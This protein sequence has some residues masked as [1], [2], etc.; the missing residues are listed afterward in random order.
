MENLELAIAEI[1]EKLPGL[2]LLENEPMAAHSSFRIGGP[3]RALAAPADVTGLSKVCDLLKQHHVA[4][5]I[6]GNGT[7][8]LFPDEGLNDLFLLSTEKLQNIFLLP[9]GAVYAE[10]GVSLARLS[11]FACE[12]GLAGLEF[13]SGIPGTL[14]GGCMMNAGAYGGELKDVI[15]SVVILYLPDQTLYELSAEQCAF[16]YRQSYFQKTPGCV[17]LSAVLRLPQ[18]D[19]DA[20]L[21][22]MQELGEKRRAKQPL[23]LPSAGSA[24]R[25]PE[26][27][28]AAALIDEAGLKGYTVGG[29]QVS[30]KHAGFV[31]NKGGATSHDVY[32][33][34]MYVRNTVYEK[35]G[36][37]LEPEI[38]ILPPDYHLEDNGPPAPRNRVIF[39]GIPEGGD[40][41]EQ[42]GG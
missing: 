24:F 32:D 22:K 4:P 41:A 28:Y 30:E 6:L 35:T 29:A 21:A 12:N 7:N 19:K 42:T 27:H 1:R 13:A 20:I 14:G 37:F 31:V 23:D 3:V 34:M 36:V 40:A 9:D 17:I 5:F 10:A 26:G 25:R 8:I 15:E 11:A 39:T 18:G 33:L 38:I 2:K 16:G